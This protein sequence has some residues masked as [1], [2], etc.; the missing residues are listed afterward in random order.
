MRSACRAWAEKCERLNVLSLTDRADIPQRTD[1]GDI[2]RYSSLA[3]RRKLYGLQEGNC[4]GGNSHFEARHFE[5]D[6]IIAK[7]KGGTDHT[8]N[9]QLLCGNCNRIKGDHGMEYLKAKLQ[10]R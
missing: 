9:L 7:Q 5:L 4:A 2:P 10:I 3:N 1:L 6:H 8:D